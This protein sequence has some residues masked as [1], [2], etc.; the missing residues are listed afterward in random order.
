MS[1]TKDKIKELTFDLVS[2]LTVIGSDDD[3]LSLFQQK[4][5]SDF[6]LILTSAKKGV[7]DS[8]AKKFVKS[9]FD[10]VIMKR[11]EYIDN[12]IKVFSKNT[13]KD[14]PTDESKLPKRYG[15]QKILADIEKQGGKATETQRMMLEVNDL[16]NIVAKLN[17]RGIPQMLGDAETLTDKQCREVIGVIQTLKN[18]IKKEK[19]L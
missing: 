5:T 10:D 8:E 13:P 19:I 15:K 17:R 4:Y 11:R 3:L 12:Y 1:E 14:E 18:K 16:K 2:V 7:L 6:K 9:I